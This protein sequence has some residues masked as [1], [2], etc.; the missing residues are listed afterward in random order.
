MNDSQ[1]KFPPARYRIMQ[2]KRAHDLPTNTF[3]PRV[4]MQRFD[5][6]SETIRHFSAQGRKLMDVTLEEAKQILVRLL[7]RDRDGR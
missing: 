4:R 3:P 5:I 1:V 6:L 2:H 7:R